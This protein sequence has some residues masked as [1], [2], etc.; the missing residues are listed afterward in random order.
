MATRK[1]DYLVSFSFQIP[2]KKISFFTFIIIASNVF[3]FLFVPSDQVLL[4]LLYDI[5]LI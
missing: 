5:Q 4:W 3:F 1:K 2:Q